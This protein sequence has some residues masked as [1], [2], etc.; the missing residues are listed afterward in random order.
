[1]CE[2]MIVFVCGYSNIGS[3][4]PR[5]AQV[6]SGETVGCQNAKMQPPPEE[7]GLPYHTIP[8]S[9]LDGKRRFYHFAHSL[10]RL[11]GSPGMSAKRWTPHRICLK[12]D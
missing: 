2:I 7:S 11:S 4:D 3:S 6:C 12:N 9:C 10:S 1:M 8:R 5:C